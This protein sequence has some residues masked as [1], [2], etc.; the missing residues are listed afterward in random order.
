MVTWVARYHCRQLSTCFNEIIFLDKWACTKKLAQPKTFFSSKS[1]RSFNK[2]R[3]HTTVTCHCAIL[4][5]IEIL[6][7]YKGT[8]F[9]PT[10]H[11][12]ARHMDPIHQ[13]WTKFG[14]DIPL[15]PR[16]KPVEAF[17]IFL[18]IQDGRRRSKVQHR[19]NFTPQIT[20]RLRIWIRFI[21]SRQYLAWT[22]YLTLETR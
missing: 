1:W 20:F 5:N 19:P 12:W 2:E 21:W 16:N 10:N 18:K 15:D 8:S 7:Y 4:R 9:D 6:V 22:Y 3:L 13:I 17:F 11:I 14:M